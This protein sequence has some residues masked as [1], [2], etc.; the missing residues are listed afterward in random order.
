[1]TPR[2]ADSRRNW[3]RRRARFRRSARAETGADNGGRAARRR[4]RAAAL[5]QPCCARPRSPLIGADSLRWGAPIELSTASCT[6]R[7][8]PPGA[9]RTAPLSQTV[10]TKLIVIW[11]TVLRRRSNSV[12]AGGRSGPVAARPGRTDHDPPP[13]GGRRRHPRSRGWP[14]RGGREHARDRRPG[15]RRMIERRAAARRRGTEA[16]RMPAPWPRAWDIG[17]ERLPALATPAL[18]PAQPRR[19]AVPAAQGSC[20]G[21]HDSTGV[22]VDPRDAPNRPRPPAQVEPVPLSSVAPPARC[23]RVRRP[24]ETVGEFMEHDLPPAARRRATPPPR[25]FCGPR[26]AKRCAR[27]CVASGWRIRATRRGGALRRGCAGRGPGV[28][29]RARDRCAA[30]CRWTS[31]VGQHRGPPGRPRRSRSCRRFRRRSATTRA[32]GSSAKTGP[33]RASR[34]AR[35]P[36]PSAGPAGEFRVRR[37]QAPS[38]AVPLIELRRF[39]RRRHHLARRETSFAKSAAVIKHHVLIRCAG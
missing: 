23:R 6:R 29:S 32:R 26:S 8:H 24:W 19:F 21:S 33:R 15:C 3:P 37:R 39:A 12:R 11:R 31:M 28:R 25:A 22:A 18:R 4:R 1:M 9:M 27:P 2:D 30:A 34:A 10:A 14:A 36:A 16:H 5:A 7:S 35:S 20:G 38:S 17:A 13:A